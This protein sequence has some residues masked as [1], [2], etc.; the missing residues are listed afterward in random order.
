MEILNILPSL[1]SGS[2]PIVIGSD[3]MVSIAGQLKYSPHKI[4]LAYEMR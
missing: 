4:A 1:F 2:E 3:L